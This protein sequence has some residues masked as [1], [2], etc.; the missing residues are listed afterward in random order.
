[1]AAVGLA[2]ETQIELSLLSAAA[3]VGALH[4][5][6]SRAVLPVALVDKAEDLMLHLQALPRL[7]SFLRS[8]TFAPIPAESVEGSN[9]WLAL[10]TN[11]VMRFNRPG[12]CSST[13]PISSCV[14][15]FS[16][17]CKACLHSERTAV[18]CISSWMQQLLQLCPAAWCHLHLSHILLQACCVAGAQHNKKLESWLKGAGKDRWPEMV[19]VAELINRILKRQPIPFDPH[20]PLPTPSATAWTAIQAVAE[21]VA[22]ITAFVDSCEPNGRAKAVIKSTTAASVSADHVQYDYIRLRKELVCLPFNLLAGHLPN[23]DLDVGR[24]MR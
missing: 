7:S 12:P 18:P 13:F 10:Y 19:T 22:D 4:S 8:L 1:M 21:Q 16:C 17:C 5:L 24:L 11:T 23:L 3:A 20:L 9:R 6:T 2:S 14:L 15:M